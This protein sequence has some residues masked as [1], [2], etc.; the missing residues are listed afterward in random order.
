MCAA[1]IK[2]EAMQGDTFGEAPG[3]EMPPVLPASPPLS[4]PAEPEAAVELETAA[5][6]LDTQ[7]LFIAADDSAVAQAPAAAERPTAP[8]YATPLPPPPAAPPFGRR[9]PP[10]PSPAGLAER[11]GAPWY[12]WVIG[13]VLGALLLVIVGCCALSGLAVGLIGHLRGAPEVSDTT[14][15]TFAVSGTPELVIRDPAGNVT[16]A[17]GATNAVR[18][19]ATRR[20]R[21]PFGA[22]AQRTLS[23]IQIQMTQSGATITVTVQFPG[24]TESAFSGDQSVD[25]D[26]TTPPS[27]NLTA[28]LAAGNLT[29]G[30]LTGRLTIMASAGNVE[31]SGITLTG[32]SR[33]VAN[34]GSVTLDGSLASGASL[35]VHVNAGNVLLRLPANTSARLDAR[36][37]VG[38]VTVS[39]WPII[40]TRL[41]ATGERASGALGA[42]PTG[43]ITI[44]VDSGNATVEAR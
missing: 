21:E 19:E 8:A 31:A 32:A 30:A 29:L 40:V 34:A 28:N 20:V 26:I 17:P 37:S 33:I 18:I 12:A 25:L 6:T 15:K 10:A 36:A 41:G 2:D 11:R 5:P 38:S 16:L 9:P 23:A 7:P 22:D 44:T 3:E 43:T 39:G 35:D 14:T 13:G 4:A 1:C 42:N 24:Q 27:S